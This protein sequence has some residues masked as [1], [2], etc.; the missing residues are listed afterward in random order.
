MKGATME[1]LPAERPAGWPA[2]L[3]WPPD[4][5]EMRGVAGLYLGFQAPERDPDEIRIAGGEVFQAGELYDEE[6]FREPLRKVEFDEAGAAIVN[7]E[8]ETGGAYARFE[9]WM[10]TDFPNKAVWLAERYRESGWTPEDHAAAELAVEESVMGSRASRTANGMPAVTGWTSFMELS[11]RLIPTRDFQ[12]L[13]A[14]KFERAERGFKTRD[15]AWWDLEVTKLA[16]RETRDE[17]HLY[18]FLYV[19]QAMY[20]RGTNRGDTEKKNDVD[21]SV[22]YGY[23]IDTVRKA[24]AQTPVAR[25]AIPH[26]PFAEL[27]RDPAVLV[28]PVAVVPRLAWEGRDTLFS[29]R[30]KLSGKSTLLT[31]AAAAVTTGGTFLGLP[32][33]RGKVLWVSADIEPEGDVVQR[34]LR[35]GGDVNRMDLRYPPPADFTGRLD[36]LAHLVAT[37]KAALVV[38]DS[39]SAFMLVEDSNQAD[40]WVN[41][42]TLLRER[43][44]PYA[45][46]RVLVHHTTKGTQEF[47]G[48]TAVA[49][50]VDQV[51]YY[52]NP[53]PR[54]GNMV[55]KVWGLGRVTGWRPFDVRLEGDAFRIAEAADEDAIDAN[56]DGVL[57]AWVRDHELRST[58]T[59]AEELGWRRTDA[60]AALER[61]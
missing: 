18:E 49:A 50:A 38:I 55:R 56:E 14:E 41:N 39:L 10:G 28:P 33:P 22:Y 48:S 36:W 15:K 9:A 24:L 29:G 45:A 58:K 13:E 12:M 2:E 60:T 25:A 47:R 51:L 32:C 19:V 23:T 17:G 37:G 3:R 57:W 1:M 16:A 40:E 31:A 53:E 5:D 54:S 8:D 52:E 59:I 26:R 43:L 20:P 6:A 44:K 46:A 27:A 21:F 7:A 61:L 35:F 34:F 42:L 11:K 4:T 30:E